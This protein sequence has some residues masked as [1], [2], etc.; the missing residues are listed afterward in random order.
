MR[1]GITKM[2]YLHFTSTE[3]YR[4]RVIQLGESPDRVF[5]V[6]ALGIE[7]IK[8]L[9]LLSKEQLEQSLHTALPSPLS[10]VTYHPATLDPFS[11][12]NQFQP[13]LMLWIPFQSYLRCLQEATPILEEIRSMKW[14][15]PIPDNIRS[16][17]Y[18]FLL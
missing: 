15:Y 18:T 13:L 2:S 5:N 12:K 14:R 9:T 8:G 3:Y 6:G 10:L 16:G 1:H 7:Q 17:R 11:A 4:K